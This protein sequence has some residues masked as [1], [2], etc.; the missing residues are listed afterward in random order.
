MQ[1]QP[2]LDYAPPPPPRRTGAG[3]LVGVAGV[4]WIV[5]ITATVPVSA[6]GY[7][8]PWWL[9]W[10]ITLGHA[11]AVF[12]MFYPTRGRGRAWKFVAAVAATGLTLFAFM[13]VAILWF[14]N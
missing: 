12:A 8:A 13:Q 14:W 3:C 2:I 6:D 1:R 5:L 9:K 11:A 7:S 10:L 4:A